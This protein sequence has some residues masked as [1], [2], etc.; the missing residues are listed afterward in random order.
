[1]DR[2]SKKYITKNIKTCTPFAR[3]QRDK[4]KKAV[5][6][7]NPGQFMKSQP[8]SPKIG[9]IFNR[10]FSEPQIITSDV[11]NKGESKTAKKQ[12]KKRRPQ[13]TLVERE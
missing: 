8:V 5:I 12:T 3:N 1:L 13:S 11:G 4:V 9:N 6:L 10:K 7:R 2:N